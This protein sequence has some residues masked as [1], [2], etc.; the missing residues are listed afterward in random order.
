MN[1]TLDALIEAAALLNESRPARDLMEVFPRTVQ[2]ELQGEE[3]PLHI[4]IGGGRMAVCEGRT[5]APDIVVAGET[6]EFTRVVK[7]ELDISH[8]IAHG[9]LRIEKGKVSDMTL[10]NRILW[11]LKRGGGA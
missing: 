2:L 9:T 3:K 8:P 7:G 10:L 6:R 5:A 11:V 1:E 4:T